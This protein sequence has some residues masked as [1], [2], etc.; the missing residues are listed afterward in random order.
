MNESFGLCLQDLSY[1]PSLQKKPAKE[2]KK[3]AQ[4]AGASNDL[5]DVHDFD[6]NIDLNMPG[7]K[8]SKT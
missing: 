8:F 7:G 3:A 5:F 1:L 6:I 2:V 4:G